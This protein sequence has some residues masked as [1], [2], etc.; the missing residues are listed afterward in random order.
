[1]ASRLDVQHLHYSS[2]P[3][4]TSK[5][6]VCQTRWE[7]GLKIGH[8]AFSDVHDTVLLVRAEHGFLDVGMVEHGLDL[9]DRDARQ[10]H[11]WTLQLECAI[12]VFI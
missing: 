10:P 8:V 9:S 2:T 5:F 12:G 4:P 6:N 7:V 3:R 11:R 1:M